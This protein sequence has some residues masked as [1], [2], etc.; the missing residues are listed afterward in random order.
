[1]DGEAGGQWPPGRA[2]VTRAPCLSRTLSRLPRELC[3]VS[4]SLVF[5][6]LDVVSYEEVVRLPAFKRKTLVLIGICPQPGAPSPPSEK[7]SERRKQKGTPED[8]V[9]P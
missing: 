6:Q 3:W 5:D 9:G 7:G 2:A 8:S 1:M 4:S